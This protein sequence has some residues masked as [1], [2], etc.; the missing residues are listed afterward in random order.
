M[1]PPVLGGTYRST[2][3]SVCEPLATR[4]YCQLKL[5]PPLFQPLSLATGQYRPR[6]K[7]EEGEEKEELGDLAFLSFDISIRRD[8]SHRSSNACRVVG[9]FSSSA[10]VA[11]HPCGEKK[12]RFL[13]I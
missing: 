11:S 8:L 10:A 6:E 2:N 12:T 5:F 13:I 9:D 3:R 4:W 1:V 7:E